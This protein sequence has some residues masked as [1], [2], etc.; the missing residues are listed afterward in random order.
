MEKLAKFVGNTVA[1]LFFLLI[2]VTFVAAIAGL[3]K[4]VLA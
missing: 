4:A 3:I 1:L 2:I